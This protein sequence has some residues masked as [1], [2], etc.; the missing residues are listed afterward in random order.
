MPRKNP[1]A[2]RD[3]EA[4]VER[5]LEI[6]YHKGNRSKYDKVFVT[7]G[8]PPVTRKFTDWLPEIEKDMERVLK[9]KRP[10]LTGPTQVVR[11][12]SL[13]G[14]KRKDSE[15]FGDATNHRQIALAT[16]MLISS[17]QNLQERLKKCKHCKRPFL[18]GNRRHD[19]EGNFCFYSDRG[20]KMNEHCKDEYNTLKRHSR[21]SR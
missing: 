12:F 20:D 18:G 14:D 1:K 4:M 3:I 10:K 21:R 17:E 2:P 11:I 16:P 19:A 5:G 6:T 7:T 13:D 8:K 9:K 15:A